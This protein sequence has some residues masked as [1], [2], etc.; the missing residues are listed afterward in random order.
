MIITIDGPTASGKSSVAQALAK[1]LGFYYLNTGMLYRAIT[2]LLITYFKYSLHDL[3]Y[4]QDDDL[5]A[6]ANHSRLHYYYD[7]KSGV[8]LKYDD[9]DITPFLKDASIDQAVCLISPQPPV[10]E[11]LSQFQRELAA[12]HNVITDGRDTGSVVFP[13]ADYKFYLTASLHV[14]ALRWQKDQNGR[15]HRYTIQEAEDRV[16]FRDNKDEN[17]NHSPLVIPKNAFVLDNSNL[18]FN[19]TLDALLTYIN[20]NKDHK[21]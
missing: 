20:D 1:K 5:T 19:E 11:A 18:D 16:A 21:N 15:G 14:R 10:R 9:I 8:C 4:V 6:C 13:Q 2:Y 7:E 17:R 12:R 3:E